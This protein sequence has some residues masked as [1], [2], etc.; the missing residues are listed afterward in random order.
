[1]EKYFDDKVPYNGETRQTKSDSD[2]LQCFLN[3]FSVGES[4][5]NPIYSKS[6]ETLRKYY[7]GAD[8]FSKEIA[9]FY[10][11]RLSSDKFYEFSQDLE[12]EAASN[13]IK[14]FAEHGIEID[15]YNFVD[16]LTEVL[17]NI[18][19]DIAYPK[20]R[21]RV[22]SATFIEHGRIK[23]GKEVINIPETL[24]S[25]TIQPD[26]Y[27]YVEALIEVYS[28]D[29]KI[30]VETI[31]LE[32][33][34]KLSPIYAD[35]FKLQREFFFKAEAAFHLLRDNFSNGLEEFEELKNETLK[36]VS[37]TL[38]DTYDSPF[39]KVNA[40]LRHVTMLTYG[41][42]Y[43]GRNNN[44]FVGTDEKQGIIHMLVNDDKIVWVK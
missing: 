44:G 14:D 34:N 39:K 25:D 23:I 15:Q 24:V 30:P 13:L 21:G 8:N 10:L 2:R 11:G 27:K 20:V 6:P 33:L 17:R 43:L 31:S 3:A 41:K 16:G 36:G 35:H 29:S 40:T 7:S 9:K 37:S 12:D 1:M 32:T 19:T 5:A 4:D 28:I 26:E 18:L 42:S 38:F 22:Q